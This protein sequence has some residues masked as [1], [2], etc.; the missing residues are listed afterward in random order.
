MVGLNEHVDLVLL[1]GSSNTAGDLS[2]K[3]EL[4][5]RSNLAFLSGIVFFILKRCR[6]HNYRHKVVV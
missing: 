1:V 4:K 6:A 5:E 2:V 3:S